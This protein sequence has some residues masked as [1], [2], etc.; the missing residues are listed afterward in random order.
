MK[1]KNQLKC[2]ETL[3][4]TLT[5]KNRRY[6]RLPWCNWWP[7]LNMQ[8]M[9]FS[10]D[11]RKLYSDRNRLHVFFRELSHPCK[12]TLTIS[13]SVFPWKIWGNTLIH[14]DMLGPFESSEAT[15][16]MN[17]LVCLFICSQ[18]ELQSIS[19]LF[20]Y[21]TPCKCHRTIN[22]VTYYTSE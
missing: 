10:K 4:T 11:Q 6:P 8:L 19:F 15:F 20:W 18:P 1:Q 3:I 12:R 7:C 17:A 13:Y 16:I 9:A 14:L 2:T 22:Y 21:L 5:S